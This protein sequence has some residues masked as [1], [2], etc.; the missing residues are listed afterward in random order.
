[1]T[2]PDVDHC[3]FCHQKVVETPRTLRDVGAGMLEHINI[4][5]PDQANA[6]IFSTALAMVSMTLGRRLNPAEATT[7][8]AVA[9]MVA[10]AIAGL[11]GPAIGTNL[12]RSLVDGDE[13]PGCA[14][15]LPLLQR[16]DQ[17]LQA[18]S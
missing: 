3:P 4:A 9:E 11:F 18:R 14:Q 16:A 17:I 7:S 5:H 10:N 12:T 15:A 1:M 6:F 2:P 8:P 13:C